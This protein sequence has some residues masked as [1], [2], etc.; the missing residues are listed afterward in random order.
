MSSQEDLPI[1]R[2]TAASDGDRGQPGETASGAES[3][4]VIPEYV[5]P[6]RLPHGGK[7][8][9]QDADHPTSN[10][11][12]PDDGNALMGHTV[13]DGR[14]RLLRRIGAGGMGIVY[15][16]HDRQRDE[17]VALKTLQRPDPA[18]LYRLK[19]EF[20]TLANVNH[21]NLV[22]LY[23][24]ISDRDMW[25]FTME[26]I[27]GVDFFTYVT[28]LPATG[29]R[30][31]DWETESLVSG[32]PKEGGRDFPQLD[33]LRHT[34]GQ[35]AEGLVA[36]HDADTLHRD[37]KP[38]NMLVT[39]SGR[40]VLLDFG[41]ATELREGRDVTTHAHLLGTAAY[42]APEQAAGSVLS[43]AADW[44]SAG[45]VLY[46]ALTGRRPFSGPPITVLMDKQNHDP[47][48]PTELKPG[49]PEDLN[50]LC[51]DLLRRDPAERPS[52]REVLRRLSC[53]A[54][55][56]G[57]VPASESAGFLSMPFVGRKEHL[58]ELEDAFQAMHRG[59]TVFVSVQGE[60]G[61][62]KSTL[63]K[64]F[65]GSLP[66]R[67][68]ALVLQG[69]CYQQESVP[70]RAL[71]AAMDD[72]SRHLNNLSRLEVEAILPRDIVPLTHVF[73]VLRRVE[74]VAQAPRSEAR[75]PD[76][77]ELRKRAF[78]ALR[79]L[80]GRL[81]DR[82]PLVLFLDDLQWGDKD[83]A[84][85]LVE[86]L[87][88]PQAPTLLVLACYRSE[89]AAQNIFSEAIDSFREIA[90]SL[91]D[92]RELAVGPLTPTETQELTSELLKPCGW[93]KQNHRE[94]VA[95]ESGG[96]PFFVYELVEYLRTTA[97]DQRRLQ[98]AEEISLGSVLW[99]RSRELPEEARR[100]LEVVA[101][102]GRP[103]ET[104]IARQAAELGGKWHAALSVSQSARLLRT[105]VRVD[106]EEVDCCHDRIRETI[107][108]RLPRDAVREHHRR[109]ALTMASSGRADPEMLAVHF[110]GAE[111]HRQARQYYAAA[112]DQA[113]GA[114]AFEH[115]ARLCR[116]ALELG[117][118][119]DE[120]ATELRIRLGDAL[121]SAGRGAEAAR[122]YLAA[123]DVSREAAIDLR[124][125]AAMHLLTSGHIEE[126]VDLL[127]TVAST[128]GI[129]APKTLFGSF[130]S[131]LLGR[132]YLM[133][134]G[135]DFDERDVAQI[136]V[137]RLLRA[138]VAYS[139]SIG[140]SLVDAISGA[141]FQTRAVLLALRTGHPYRIVRA[142]AGH[143]AHMAASGERGRRRAA[144]L[145][146]TLDA[147]A[148][149]QGSPEALGWVSLAAG[150]MASFEGQWRAVLERCD[151]A[152]DIFRSRCI[153]V[154]WEL[155]SAH[156]FSLLALVLLG[157]IA[158]FRRRR[159]ILL[160]EAHQRGD[161][162]LLNGLCS[163][164]SII[165][166]LAADDPEGA[167]RELDEAIGQWTQRGFHIQHHGAIFARMLIDL[168]RGDGRAAWRRVGESQA[169]YRYSLQ[170]WIQ[171]LRIGMFQIRG[172]AALAASASSDDLR[173]L[174]RV[175]RR[176]A[177]RLERER[178]PYAAAFAR[179]IRAGVGAVAGETEN[180][181]G[182]L[183]EAVEQFEAA[184]M[185]LVAAAARRRLG[186]AL[187]GDEG[188][189]L[190]QQAD[191]WMRSQTIQNPSRMAAMYTPG[192]PPCE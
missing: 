88:P 127:R 8:A 15:Q 80:L 185:H 154:A 175:A 12:F 21:P 25:F 155:N 187:G 71:D 142:L 103:L 148:Q 119:Q 17:V 110:H 117:E 171:Q 67:V 26:F 169:G 5:E 158:E 159:A 114:L 140:L 146:R 2:R 95:C 49:L 74:A 54:T 60:S 161:L 37:I 126:G 64:H 22:V 10:G 77:G 44:Y 34:F 112:A 13:G 122:E 141:D 31:R 108:T 63:V 115:A 101:V 65:L 90:G 166:R 82:T 85:L 106:R 162:Y 83:S 102:A 98:S 81:A 33:R 72:L 29:G 131:L 132:S 176:A 91:L 86:L 177:G 192:F 156:L 136:S 145:M 58:S 189:E 186:E 118:E 57:R 40:L 3:S 134:R 150:V 130:C 6:I 4:G 1:D 109:L 78:A 188:R 30:N 55:G 105:A 59:R 52:G 104:A 24:L 174:L 165:D 111:Q 32:S 62:G 128:V 191:A 35:L 48:P 147:L 51:I 27:E 123:A 129:R 36:L 164:G 79:E 66:G 70:F 73:P 89:D 47:P 167:E 173:P 133:L 14:F 170:Q 183:R 135:A 138:D 125:R 39:D 93:A 11:Q 7:S 124:R 18:L 43:P 56:S 16:A 69:R 92:W 157:E 42:M 143:A 41:L 139:A 144:R 75:V 28:A 179:L 94:T 113:F 20:R 190:V 149:R 172:W 100:L 168:Y 84:A 163:S 152:I 45:V 68:K 181:V 9:E 153:G 96:T 87:K 97:G 19:R 137:K 116:A 99:R 182:L 178:I 76:L 180:A 23:E 38:S 120:Q 61:Q 107:L 160:E 121:A 46:E 53:P 184:D 151:H 50:A